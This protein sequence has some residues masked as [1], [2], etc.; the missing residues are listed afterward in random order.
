MDQNIRIAETLIKTF[1]AVTAVENAPYPLN[2]AAASEA[3]ASGL[4]RVASIKAE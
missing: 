2:V 4:A 3:L 1:Q